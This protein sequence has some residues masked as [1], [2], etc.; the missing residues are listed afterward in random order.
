MSQGVGRCHV[1]SPPRRETSLEIDDITTQ[2]AIIN[3]FINIMFMTFRDYSTWLVGLYHGL[4]ARVLAPVVATLVVVQQSVVDRPVLSARS[5]AVLPKRKRR[6]SFGGL[7]APPP[8]TPAA[9]AR[10]CAA[11][12]RSEE[13]RV[14]KE[15]RSRWSPYH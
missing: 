12:T 6:G 14:G 15:C 7:A 1:D 4:L 13:R 3:L 5:R 9:A 11:T 8:T 2:W 10:A